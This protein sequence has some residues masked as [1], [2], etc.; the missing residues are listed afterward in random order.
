[1]KGFAGATHFELEVETSSIGDAIECATN[2][3]SSHV[4]ALIKGEVFVYSA[5]TKK[6]KAA[7]VL[8]L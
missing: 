4:G 1:V 5:V 7:E 6:P 3:G 8:A 2:L